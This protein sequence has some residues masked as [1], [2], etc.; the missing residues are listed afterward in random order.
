MCRESRNFMRYKNLMKKSFE[1]QPLIVSYKT[2]NG[3]AL[4]PVKLNTESSIFYIK[5]PVDLV[6]DKG[7][8]YVINTGISFDMP[9]IVETY[10]SKSGEKSEYSKLLLQGRLSSSHELASKSGILLITPTII[11]PYQNEEISLLLMNLGDKSAKLSIGDVIAE[12]S[13]SLVPRI[14]LNVAFETKLKR[15]K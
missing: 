1:I 5:S 12:L 9:R 13:F 4:Y 7:T 8:R 15:K 6:M 10:I 11:E 14:N 2:S 3:P